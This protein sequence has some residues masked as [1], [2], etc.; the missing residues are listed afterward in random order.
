MLRQKKSRRCKIKIFWKDFVK[1]GVV[2]VICYCVL[3]LY[4]GSHCSQYMV[5][6]VR[7]LGQQGCERL[8][9]SPIGSMTASYFLHTIAPQCN[10]VCFYY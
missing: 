8:A 10:L 6:S 4:R 2:V 3:A 7:M 5:D 9:E 1:E